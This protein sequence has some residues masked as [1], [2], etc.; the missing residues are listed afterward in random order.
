MIYKIAHRI[1]W[2]FG[3]IVATIGQAAGYTHFIYRLGYVEGQTNAKAELVKAQKKL[4][5]SKGR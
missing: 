5:E 4:Q 3:W 2:V 1:G